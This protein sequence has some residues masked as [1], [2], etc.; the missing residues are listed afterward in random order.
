MAYFATLLIV[1]IEDMEYT[2]LVL[3]QQVSPEL[4]KRLG[5]RR[6]LTQSDIVVTNTL[7]KAGAKRC[8]F[9]GSEKGRLDHAIREGSVIGILLEDNI[10]AKS[11]IE[12]AASE[13]KPLFLAATHLTSSDTRERLRNI[14]RMRRLFAFARHARARLGLITLAADA[15]ELLSSMQ[16]L[17]IAMMLGA[18]EPYAKAMLE[19]LGGKNDT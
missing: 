15:S 17:E 4:A 6:I 1:W 18:E 11:V 7:G 12:H 16:M 9:T 13:E 3:M 8:L 2:D 10:E 5:Y 19:V 14:Y